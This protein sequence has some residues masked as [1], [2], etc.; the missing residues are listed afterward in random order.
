MAGAYATLGAH[1]LYCTPYA[2]A[3][4][5]LPGGITLKVAP[6][7][8]QVLPPAVADTVTSLLA[9]VVT[10]GTGTGAAIAGHT[11][12][13]KTGTTSNFGSAWFDGYTATT[14]MAVWMGDPR[15]VTYPLYN[16]AGVAAVYGGTLPAEMFKAAMTPILKGQPNV[17]I[18]PPTEI[19]LAKSS[20]VVPDVNDLTVADA[21]ALLQKLGLV[22]SG[23]VNGV[24]G[25]T[26]PAAGTYVSPGDAVTLHPYQGP[27]S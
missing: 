26:S 19:Y 20:E 3:A 9:G 18:A 13:G 14:A 10:S 12:A 16:V 25:T 5:T 23:P 15:G 1:G 8:A 11:L 24:A 6:Q 2:V 27:T 17:P 21:R 4:V 7:C 22:V